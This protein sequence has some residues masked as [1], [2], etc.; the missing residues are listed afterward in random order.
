MYE[1]D[2]SEILLTEEQIQEKIK[3]L[4]K[5]ISGEYRGKDL[6]L[7]GVLKGAVVFMADL[8][9]HISI[10]LSFDFMAASSYRDSSQSSGRV[11]ILKDLDDDVR[12]R[13]V[14]F[15]EDI[16]DTGLTLGYLMKVLKSR[17]PAS[18]RI[19][20]LL[21]KPERREIEV[22]VD[23][24][25]FIIP[26]RFVVGYGLDYN[27]RYRNAPFIFIPKNEVFERA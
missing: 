22:K 18:L 10:P 14:L 1:D 3:E 19:C 15:I 9:R 2:I 6:F 8:I 20:A 17:K 23:F 21:N 26:N 27:E 7:I 24:S 25:G 11:R 13:N 5:V 12:D 4:G 16:I